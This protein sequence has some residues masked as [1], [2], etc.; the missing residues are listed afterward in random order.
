MANN[1]VMCLVSAIFIGASIYT[2][3]TCETCKPFTDYKDS[4]D[5]NLQELYQKVVS[6]RKKIYIQG[7]V[8]GIVVSMAYFYWQKDTLNPLGYSCIFV[9]IVMGVQY[10]YYSLYPKSVNMLTNLRS[11]EQIDGWWAVYETMKYRYHM[12]A[13]FGFIGYFLLSYGILKKID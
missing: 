13:L 9:G 4:L 10:L 6:E 8:I 2:V 7:L 11:K 12:G 3:I 1:L 5:S